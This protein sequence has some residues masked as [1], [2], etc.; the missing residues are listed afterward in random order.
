MEGG[1]GGVKIPQS[2]HHP[3]ITLY[4]VL[5]DLVYFT[6]PLVLARRMLANDKTDEGPSLRADKKGIRLSMVDNEI[7]SFA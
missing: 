2:T 5:Q 6:C 1:G 7:F 3:M 4:P